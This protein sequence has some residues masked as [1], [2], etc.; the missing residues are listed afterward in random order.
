MV[1]DIIYRH[2]SSIQQEEIK[3]VSYLSGANRG[4]VPS[5]LLWSNFQ[6]FFRWVG[7]TLLFLMIEYYFVGGQ[8]FDYFVGA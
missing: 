1:T 4:L 8:N 3:W 5:L 7:S 6:N 2:S